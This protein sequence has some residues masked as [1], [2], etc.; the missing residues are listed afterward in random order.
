MREKSLVK[1]FDILA[2]KYNKDLSNK[3]MLDFFAREG[4]WQTKHIQDR[5]ETICAWEINKNFKNKLIYNLP[6]ANISI[7]DS[8]TLSKKCNDRFDII[9]IDNPQYRYGKNLEYCEHFEALEVCLGLLKS[10]GIV[11]FNVKTK[12]FNYNEKVDWQIIRN[13]F[14][15]VCDASS[16][17]ENFII[18]FYKK[19]LKERKWNI[20]YYILEKRHQEEGLYAF[21][22]G[23]SL[24]NN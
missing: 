20:D 7:G 17:S 9:L 3:N 10:Q 19:Y 11:I 4:E 8:F 6:N 21:A 2:A 23:V 24:E 12:P 18:S 1:I 15:D 16:L 13:N 14:Y 5:V 22:C